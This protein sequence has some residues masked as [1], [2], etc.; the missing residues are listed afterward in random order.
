ML[1]FCSFKEVLS[2]IALVQAIIQNCNLRLRFYLLKRENH[3]KAEHVV[4]LAIP[5]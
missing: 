3:P 4:I 1:S 2:F 5:Y